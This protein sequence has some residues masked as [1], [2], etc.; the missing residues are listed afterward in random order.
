MKIEII[1][2]ILTIAHTKGGVGKSTILN[3]IAIY[4]LS[5][6][7]KIRVADCD[8]NKVTTFISKRRAKNT[9]LKNFTSTVIS[10]P[11]ELEK[12]CNT[13]FDGITVIDTAG[14][15]CALTRKAI[16][17]GTI[18]IVPVA[19]VTTE[20]IGFATFKAVTK[21][22]NINPSK[23]K[24][25][26]NQVHIRAKDFSYFK[27][28]ANSPFDYFDTALPRLAD[29]DSP[30]LKGTGATE[31]PQVKDAKTKELK[32]RTSSLRIKSLTNEILT[33]LKQGA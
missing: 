22:I 13:P 11:Q 7:Y 32:E 20:F 4:L 33:Y 27:D 19:P 2:G 29:Y 12:F 9:K 14:V 5:L 8:P 25:V 26:I 17:L 16:E 24:V 31:L 21:K 18:T 6:G 23:I 1:N 3:Q 28:G 30:L 15:D 10:T